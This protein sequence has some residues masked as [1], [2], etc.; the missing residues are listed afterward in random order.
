MLMIFRLFQSIKVLMNPFKIKASKKK[1][2]RKF[3]NKILLRKIMPRKN[4]K[5]NIE[6]IGKKLA[7]PKSKR[8]LLLP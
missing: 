8:I 5:R 4:K 3:I 2:K 7:I 6:G 1:L